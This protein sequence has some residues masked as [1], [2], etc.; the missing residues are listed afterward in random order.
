L[1]IWEAVWFSTNIT[2]V[3]LN[4]VSDMI[5]VTMPDA[6]FRAVDESLSFN[7]SSCDLSDLPVSDKSKDILMNDKARKNSIIM[8][9]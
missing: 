1:L 7:H 5:P 4:T 9:G 3:K 2:I 6:I 8:I